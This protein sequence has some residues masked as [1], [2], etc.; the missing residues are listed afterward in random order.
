MSQYRIRPHAARASPESESKPVADSG[1]AQPSRARAMCAV[2]KPW[3][4][5]FGMIHVTGGRDVHRVMTGH[6]AGSLQEA[7]STI[8]GV[9]N[10]DSCSA[11]CPCHEE[12]RF[13]VAER[14]IRN[15]FIILVCVG[16]DRTVETTQKRPNDCM[17]GLPRS[18]RT[19]RISERTVS[20][21]WCSDSSS[22][23]RLCRASIS[24]PDRNGCFGEGNSSSA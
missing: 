14:Q 12:Q 11:P 5:S 10:R 1:I 24:D 17:S 2:V 13:F 15:C 8:S 6:A 3:I 21:Y 16:V 9:K 4:L 7:S 22:A 19:E 20:A 23:P 18:A